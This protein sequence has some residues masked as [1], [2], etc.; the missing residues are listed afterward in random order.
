MKWSDFFLFS[1]F[2]SE[3]ENEQLRR[4]NE[5]LRRQLQD[6]EQEEQWEGDQGQ[7]DWP[8]EDQYYDDQEGE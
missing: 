3:D 6:L 7:D 2:V 8:D 5:A 1:W 4:E